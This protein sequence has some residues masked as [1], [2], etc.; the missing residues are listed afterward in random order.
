[1]QPKF[2]GAQT[3]RVLRSGGIGLLILHNLTKSNRK[4]LTV[5]SSV[6]LAKPILGFFPMPVIRNAAVLGL[7]LCW[8][9]F[10][11][12]DNPITLTLPQALERARQAFAD[13]PNQFSGIAF[14][15]FSIRLRSLRAG[16]KSSAAR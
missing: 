4:S 1:M 7:K 8:G 12:A 2:S 15:F 11:Q 9:A 16:F 6:H 14:N 13:N 5:S 10:G 3:V